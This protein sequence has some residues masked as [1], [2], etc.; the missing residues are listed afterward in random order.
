MDLGDA[1]QRAV[2]DL[3]EVGV[4]HGR[5]PAPTPEADPWEDGDA[6]D[7]GGGPVV[8][9]YPGVPSVVVRLHGDGHDLVLVEDVVELEVERPDTAGVVE[10]V[11]AGRARARSATRGALGRFLAVLLHNALGSELV[12]TVPRG[13]GERTY[14]APVVVS[15][16]ASPWLLRLPW[17]DDAPGGGTARR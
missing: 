5:P 4:R 11:L 6:L 7:V 13:E 9:E 2:R 3:W 14:T 12:V 10:A 15:Y 1:T 16:G 8:V 17:T